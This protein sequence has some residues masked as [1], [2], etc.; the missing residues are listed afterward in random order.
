MKRILIPAL[1]LLLN[2][3]GDSQQA[4]FMMGTGERSLSLTRQQAYYGADWTTELVVANMPAC[5]RRHALA[6]V[7]ADKLKMDVYRPEPGVFILNTGKRWYVTELK[8]CQLQQYKEPP[9][10]PGDLIG[11]F[12]LKNGQLDYIDKE[13]KKPDA[14]GVPAAAVPPAPTSSAGQ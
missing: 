7:V 1:A 3:C 9:P 6:G 10:S 2:A 11:T 13:P 4:A 5:M 12:Q 14:P 8:S